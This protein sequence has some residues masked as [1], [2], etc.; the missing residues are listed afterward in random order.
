M[1]R[2]RV[3]VAVL[4]STLPGC[5]LLRGLEKGLQAPTARF[6]SA[7]IQ[8]VSLES[9][10]VLAHLTLHNPNLLGV[11]VAE[12]SWDFV[13]EGDRLFGGRAPSGV[14]LAPQGD[15]PLAVQVIVPYSGLAKLAVALATRDEVPY[16]VEARIG[17]QTPVG[18]LT[19]PAGWNGTLPVPKL[20]SVRLVGVRA[21]EIGFTG[22][23]AVVTLG[24]ENRNPFPIP[25]EA[26][27][28]RLLAEGRAL[29]SVGGAARTLAPRQE[30]LLELPVEIS[31][32]QAGSAAAS[33][34]A[35]RNLAVRLQGE[36]KAG[37]RALPVDL[38]ATLR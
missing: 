3:L 33:A 18:V 12:V 6:E 24:V 29:A 9:A 37:G 20:P 2:S 8:A 7:E 21:G 38:G 31:F 19:V 23:R 22:V 4:L 11:Q 28:L 17:V 30:S 5:A 10:T 14:R 25:L 26:V 27:S 16:R 32:A 15:A 1:S 34:L 13:V 36:L 35:A